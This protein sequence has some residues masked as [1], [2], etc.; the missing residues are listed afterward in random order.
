MIL[1]QEY[2]NELGAD[3]SFTESDIDVQYSNKKF[4]TVSDLNHYIEELG[5]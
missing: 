3:N 2:L 5:S 4:S 1:M